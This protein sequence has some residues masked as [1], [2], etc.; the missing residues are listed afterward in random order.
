MYKYYLHNRVNKTEC[1]I[2]N[3]YGINTETLYSLT[4]TYILYA[5]SAT[6]LGPYWDHHQPLC[7]QT[8][9]TK[10]NVCTK[11]Y[12]SYTISQRPPG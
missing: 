8:L 1:K 9:R 6:C 12:T 10:L 5:I 3:L 2:S 4:A 7:I 11:I